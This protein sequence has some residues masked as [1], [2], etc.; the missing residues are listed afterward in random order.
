MVSSMSGKWQELKEAIDNIESQLAQNNRPRPNETMCRLLIAGEDRRFALHPGV[1]PIA[2]IRAAWKTFLC[3][4]RQG[5][6]TIAMQL[7]RTITG[8]CEITLRRKIQEMILAVRLTHYLEKER[9][10]L[11]YLWIGRYGWRMDGFS[12]A[13][14]ALDIDPETVNHWQAAELV[15]RLKYPEPR[16]FNNPQM[17]KIERRARHLVSLD[18]GA[19]KKRSFV[20]AQYS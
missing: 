19:H 5:A 17:L 11:L 6:S 7:V 10:P 18:H 4:D 9:L 2:V 1:D 3:A 8:R 14:A 15:A 20:P 16:R 12:E 13:C